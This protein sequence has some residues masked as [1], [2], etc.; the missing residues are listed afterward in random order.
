MGMQKLQ[1]QFQGEMFYQ[2]DSEEEVEEIK[3]KSKKE[4]S[5][6]EECDQGS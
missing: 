5:H 4:I 2:G 6:L 1:L 3:I